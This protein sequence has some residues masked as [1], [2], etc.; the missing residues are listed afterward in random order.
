MKTYKQVQQE[1]NVHLRHELKEGLGECTVRERHNF[2]KWW[3]S[4]GNTDP[5]VQSV[6]DSIDD[7]MLRTVYHLIY[8]TIQARTPK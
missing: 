2:I 7:A 6:L 4:K 8:R 5:S 3:G 1:M